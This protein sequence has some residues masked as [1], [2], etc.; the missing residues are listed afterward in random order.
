MLNSNGNGVGNVMWVEKSG[1]TYFDQALLRAVEVFR[2]SLKLMLPTQED[3]KK[4]VL[5]EGLI[6]SLI[7]KPLAIIDF[8]W[9]SCATQWFLSWQCQ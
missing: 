2:S 4:K 5:K 8:I 7:E 6:L 3:L 1:N 9:I